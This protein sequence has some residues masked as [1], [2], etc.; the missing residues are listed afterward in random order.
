[1][2]LLLHSYDTFVELTEYIM[3]SDYS[4]FEKV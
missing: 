2:P 4:I 1:M 3:A